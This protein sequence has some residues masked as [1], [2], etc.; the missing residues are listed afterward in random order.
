MQQPL[1]LYQCYWPAKLYRL[2]FQIFVLLLLSKE[3]I[4]QQRMQNTEEEADFG[5]HQQLSNHRVAVS[6]VQ[7][8]LLLFIDFKQAVNSLDRNETWNMS[9]GFKCLQ[10]IEGADRSVQESLRFLVKY[11]ELVRLIDE[12]Q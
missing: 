4:M 11:D 9:T 12:E 8:I 3:I 7:R 10:D 5:Q 6:E 2:R 1:T